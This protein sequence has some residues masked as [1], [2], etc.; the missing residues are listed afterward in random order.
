MFAL[1]GIIWIEHIL[2]GGEIKRIEQK[3]RKGKAEEL[4]KIKTRPR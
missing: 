3:R 2:G 1:D 4:L